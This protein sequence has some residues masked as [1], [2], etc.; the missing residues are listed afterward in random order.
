MSTLLQQGGRV[1]V[2]LIRV[3]I[4]VGLLIGCGHGES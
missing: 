4:A 3:A 2:H 1:R